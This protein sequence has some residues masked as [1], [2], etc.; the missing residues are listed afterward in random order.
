M[1]DKM[2]TVVGKTINVKGEIVGQEP[3][4]IEGRVEGKVLIESSVLVRE[5]GIVFADINAHSITVAG[6]ITGNIVASDKIEILRGGVMIG[7]IK[8]PRVV[9]NDGAN[10]RGNVEMD[11]SSEKIQ[12][13][14]KVAAEAAVQ[15]SRPIPSSPR[16]Q[17]VISE[18]NDAK[19]A[20][21]P[22]P[23]PNEIIES[24]RRA[25]SGLLSRR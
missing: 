24:Q 3:L 12:E 13:R 18:S 21:T 20:S 19:S 14:Q 10:L 1:N 2:Q 15:S 4:T 25:F 17:E 11:T 22:N 7:D 16:P 23:S 6:S 5:S 9:I 8:A